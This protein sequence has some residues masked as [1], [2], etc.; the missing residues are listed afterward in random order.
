MTRGWVH[1]HSF[2]S[3]TVSGTPALEAGD[4]GGA[5]TGGEPGGDFLVWSSCRS[6]PPFRPA[7]G[8]VGRLPKTPLLLVVELPLIPSGGGLSLH[9]MET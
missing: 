1:S 8:Q 5:F 6:I 3:L 2:F 4:G 7:F 9:F